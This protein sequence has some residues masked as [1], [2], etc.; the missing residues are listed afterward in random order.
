[1]LRGWQRLLLGLTLY[2]L[3]NEQC[4]AVQMSRAAFCC[5]S[6]LTDCGALMFAQQFMMRQPAFG[7]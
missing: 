4:R 1:M 2:R 6:D 5:A 3:V 7:I